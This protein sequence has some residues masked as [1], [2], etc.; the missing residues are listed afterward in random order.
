MDKKAKDKKGNT[1]TP[2]FKKALA[3]IKETLQQ[4]M[5]QLARQNQGLA[6]AADPVGRPVA[7]QIPEPDLSGLG[8]AFPSADLPPGAE[9]PPS[10]SLSKRRPSVSRIVVVLVRG[11]W[12]TLL[13]EPVEIREA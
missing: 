1:D 8:I 2:Q 13:S 7:H 12:G 11:P 9:H 3:K 5:E 6:E 10:W 4:I